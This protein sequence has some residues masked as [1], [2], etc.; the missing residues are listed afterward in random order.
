MFITSKVYHPPSEN[1]GLPSTTIDMDNMTVKEIEEAVHA[2]FQQTLMELGVGYVDLMLLHWP[3][4]GG[5]AG[6]GGNT[7]TQTQMAEI[8]PMKRAKRIAAWKVLEH[9]YSIGWARAIGVS[10]FHEVH[11]EHL[12]DDGAKI[13]PML[14]QIET[15]IYIQQEKI[16]DYCQK[17]N[18]AVMAYS[19]L[20]RGVMNIDEDEVV[21]SI[22]NKHG[23]TPGH[24]A[25]CFL[26]HKGFA[27]SC[28]S[29]SEERIKANA[30]VCSLQL[31]ADDME[32]LSAL[33]RSESW[34]LPSPYML[35]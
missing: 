2:H 5:G 13:R 24:V 21:T 22:A 6:Q 31:D 35:P 4:S 26:L 10:N 20:G 1:F 18:I 19:P 27:L 32:K 25:L 11:L 34:G 28:W 12:M 8:D 3:S 30:S 23:V 33:N 17:H 14:N 29:S 15:S 7:V 9:Y 16:I